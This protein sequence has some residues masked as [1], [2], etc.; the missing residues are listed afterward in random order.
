MSSMF[1]LHHARHSAWLK[2]QHQHPNQISGHLHHF[3]HKCRLR[4]A[5]L[6]VTVTCSFIYSHRIQPQ[7]QIKSL[8]C[9]SLLLLVNKS[10]ALM[11]PAPKLLQRYRSQKSGEINVPLQNIQSLVTYQKGRRSTEGQAP[12]EPHLADGKTAAASETATLCQEDPPKLMV[13]FSR[14]FS[15]RTAASLESEFNN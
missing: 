3:H 12:A 9:V 10:K 6:K 4:T 1:T 15:F 2:P 13:S 5:K 11:M 8:F 7:L 14:I